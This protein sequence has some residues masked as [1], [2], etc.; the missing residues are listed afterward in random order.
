MNEELYRSFMIESN[1]NLKLVNRVPEMTHKFIYFLR[2]KG[3]LSIPG[4]NGSQ[5]QRDDGEGS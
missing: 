1:N 2:K 3:R 5:R 4:N